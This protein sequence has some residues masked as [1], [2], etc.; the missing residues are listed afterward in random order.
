MVLRV[1]VLAA[2]LTNV[3]TSESKVFLTS[4][5]SN[6]FNQHKAQEL[7]T[8]KDIVLI[9]GH[10]EGVDERILTQVDEELSLGDFVMTGGEITA[11][12]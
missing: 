1:D 9:A 12:A 8:L 7:S 4:A 3:K 11:A 2:A 10:Y 6:P 5:K